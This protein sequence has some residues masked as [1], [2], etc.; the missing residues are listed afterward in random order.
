[1]PRSHLHIKVRP[2]VKLLRRRLKGR[3]SSG[4]EGALASTLIII[5]TGNNYQK[6]FFVFFFWCFQSLFE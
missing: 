6:L 4:M 2:V 3:F 5:V 1:M